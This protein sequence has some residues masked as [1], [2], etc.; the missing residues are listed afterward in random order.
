MNISN[1]LKRNIDWSVLYIPLNVKKY[2]E[3]QNKLDLIYK[4][5]SNVM[6]TSND[7]IEACYNLCE[8]LEDHAL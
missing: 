1:F 4:H 7:G 8:K 2:T 5:L 6:P 3:I